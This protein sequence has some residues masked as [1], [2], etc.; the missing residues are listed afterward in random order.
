MT[1][2]LASGFACADP[3]PADVGLEDPHVDYMLH[4]QGCHLPDLSGSPG[5]VPG[6]KGSVGELA[7]TPEGR[8]YLLRVPGS[9]QSRLTDSRLAALLNWIVDTWNAETKP[10]DFQPFTADEVHHARQRPLVDALARREQIVR[11]RRRNL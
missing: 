4:C 3:R 9:S 7:R 6:L 1:L 10:A 11:E 2:V 5:I 8:D